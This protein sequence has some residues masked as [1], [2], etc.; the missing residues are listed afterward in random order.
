MET[1]GTDDVYNA[2]MQCFKVLRQ[3]LSIYSDDEGALNSNK[4]Q[5]FFQR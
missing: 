4:L 5:S 1:N 3:P 2:V